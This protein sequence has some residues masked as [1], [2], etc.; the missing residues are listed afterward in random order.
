M[1][2]I[3]VYGSLNYDLVYRLP[4]IVKP[5]ETLASYDVSRFFGGK[6]LNQSVAAARA[7][8][9][10]LHAGCLGG[11]G[12]DIL[13]FLRNEG[14][15][16]R[17]LAIREDLSTGVAL[18]QLD[19]RG[20]NAIVLFG[21]ANQAVDNAVLSRMEQ[22]LDEHVLLVLQNE[23]SRVDEA[24]ALAKQRKAR[25]LFNPAP[26]DTAVAGYPLDRVDYL[27][28]NEH[29]SQAL[30]GIEDPRAACRQLLREVPQ[31]SVII[32]LGS[33]GALCVDE[34]NALKHVPAQA[35]NTLDTTAAGDT[36]IGYLAAALLRGAPVSLAVEEG[37]RA[38]AV[39]VSRMGA[40]PSI[41]YRR[42]VSGLN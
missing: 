33:E 37:S 11:D 14:I 9:R 32:T 13:S 31:R 36:F 39:A 30:T 23:T 19:D 38:A 1:H 4:H 2:S 8:A 27:V 28:L 5:G 35:A 25:V 26:M 42:E 34:A 17:L 22:V 12:G 10:V 16:C 18:I 7:G 6:G 41:P 40:V 21:G 29:E 3:V 24:I 15:D 20:E